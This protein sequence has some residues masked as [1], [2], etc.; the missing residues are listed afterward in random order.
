MPALGL[1]RSASVVSPKLCQ[2]DDKGGH[3]LPLYRPFP[4]AHL[5]VVT[6]T[7][8][9]VTCATHSW[10]LRFKSHCHEKS[11]LSSYCSLKQCFQ[12]PVCIFRTRIWFP[13][14]F[15]TSFSFP[16]GIWRK[17]NSCQQK[18]KLVNEQVHLVNQ[19]CIFLAG[20]FCSCC[21]L[22]LRWH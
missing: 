6:W 3:H 20:V 2:V 9:T 12:F 11:L 19:H 8:L 22:I 1:S 4:W 15:R 7:A 13:F 5:L 10:P 14:F 21:K 18:L 17:G 16:M